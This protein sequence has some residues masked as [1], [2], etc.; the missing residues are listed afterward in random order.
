MSMHE[1]S[2]FQARNEDARGMVCRNCGRA[3]NV[4]DAAYCKT[5]QLGGGVPRPMPAPP[6]PHPATIAAIVEDEA[7]TRERAAVVRWLLLAGHDALGL[8]VARG[9]HRR[10]P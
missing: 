4:H 9:D 3:S 10:T 5:V 6:A 2:A 8:A 1:G 7:T